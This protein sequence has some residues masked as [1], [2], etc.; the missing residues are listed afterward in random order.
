M[1]W[2][3]CL[4][5]LFLACSDPLG[6]GPLA[7]SFEGKNGGVFIPHN[8]I[9]INNIRTWDIIVVIG[10]SGNLTWGAKFQNDGDTKTWALNM[11][12]ALF[13]DS[14]RTSGT[15]LAI[16]SN[17]NFDLSPLEQEDTRRS[18][19]TSL[20]PPPTEFYWTFSWGER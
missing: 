17:K 6:P 10:P 8:P 13:P 15:E 19:L 18:D 14:L 4:I 11:K 1:R 7:G 16:F 9:I 3:I 2:L 12:I 5:P 20:N